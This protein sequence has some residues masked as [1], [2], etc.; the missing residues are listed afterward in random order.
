[1]VASHSELGKLILDDEVL[2]PLLLRKLVSEPETVVIEAETDDH[3]RLWTVLVHRTLLKSDSQFVV[4]VADVAF[5]TP[6]WLPCLIEGVT[7]HPGHLESV[8]ETFRPGVEPAGLLLKSALQ[9]LAAN[10]V[11]KLAR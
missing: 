8:V 5:L 6:D 7:F 11:A 4:V 2:E 9:A 3:H 10:L 1:M